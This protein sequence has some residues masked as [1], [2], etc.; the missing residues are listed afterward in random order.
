[1]EVWRDIKGYEGIYQISNLGR[2]RSLNRK[3]K[4]KRGRSITYCGK[5]LKQTP[6]SKGYLRVPLKNGGQKQALFVHRLVALHFVENPKPTEFDVVNHLDSNYLNNRADN[7]EWTNAVGNMRHA[8]AKGRMDRTDE[9]LEHLH[10]GL[11][12]YFAPVIGYDPKTGMTEKEF[13]SIQE[14]GRNGFCTASVCCCCKGK[15]KT[16]KGL[17]WKYANPSQEVGAING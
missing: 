16:H 12:P 6:N 5:I 10:E 2:V 3:R 15:R 11:K 17:A 1:M 9:W 4:D 13:E 7:L 14:A 8:I